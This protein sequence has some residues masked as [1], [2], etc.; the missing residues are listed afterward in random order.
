MHRVKMR[1]IEK[2]YM[3]DKREVRERGRKREGARKAHRR[4]ERQ[5]DTQTDRQ[6]QMQTGRQSTLTTS[7][8]QGFTT[9]Y[10]LQGFPLAASVM[11]VSMFVSLSSIL[12]SQTHSF[13]FDL[14]S[15]KPFTPSHVS[16]EVNL[17]TIQ[18]FG[19]GN[20]RERETATETDRET[21]RCRERER[22]RQRQSNSIS[23]NDH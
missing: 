15:R 20:E 4:T 10:C 18:C 12:L 8:S 16:L 5:A 7:K 13:A 17:E 21:D 14:T 6:I 23:S 1:Y 19:C 22:E 3:Q 9:Q 11:H 2:L